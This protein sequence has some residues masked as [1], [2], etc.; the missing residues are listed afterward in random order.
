MRVFVQQVKPQDVSTS[1]AGGEMSLSA[2]ANAYA[3]ADGML[4]FAK[5]LTLAA[6]LLSGSEGWGGEQAAGEEASEQAFHGPSHS[7]IM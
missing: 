3:A 2:G 5:V 7:F 6:S 1:A 4:N